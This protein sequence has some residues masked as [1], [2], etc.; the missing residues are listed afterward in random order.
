MKHWYM[1]RIPNTSTHHLI[2]TMSHAA[3]RAISNICRTTERRPGGGGGL[4][5]V[6]LDNTLAAARLFS[7]RAWISWCHSASWLWSVTDINGR[8]R[9]HIKPQTPR[10]LKL[11]CPV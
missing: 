1:G 8:H 4:Q 3:S 2:C 6:D 7:C 11:I 10:Y 5:E 9:M